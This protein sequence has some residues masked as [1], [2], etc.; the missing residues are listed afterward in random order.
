LTATSISTPAR[1]K[2]TSVIVIAWIVTLIIST[3]PMILWREIVGQEPAWLF[4]A[5]LAVLAIMLVTSFAWKAIS[6]LRQY[7][8]VL[9]VLIIAEWA[10]GI[11][12]ST[13]QWKLWFGSVSFSISMLGTQLLRLGV[14]LVMVVTMF[15]LKRQRSRF[16]LVRGTTDAPVAPIPWLGVKEGLGW[17]RFGIILSLCISLGTLAFVLFFGRPSLESILKVTPFLPAILLL[18]VLN[19]FSEEMNYRA[20]ELSALDGVINAPQALL[21]TAYFFGIGHYYGVPYGVVGVLMA[22]VLG[23]L[24]GK[25]M[26]ETKGFFWAWF[27]HFLQDVVIFSFMAIGSIVAGGG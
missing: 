22:G 19:S 2:Q 11:I 21:L 6:G 9:L 26:L 12:A 25:S 7:F 24:L 5:K 17:K 16:F 13:S 8:I 14:A 4:A 15:V 23:W 10:T 1:T 18:A 20:S 27:I 3:L